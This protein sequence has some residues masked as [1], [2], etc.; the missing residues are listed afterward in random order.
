M[1]QPCSRFPWR[2]LVSTA[3]AASLALACDN[4]TPSLQLWRG[5]LRAAEERWHAA[6][7]TDYEYVVSVSGSQRRTRPVRATVRGGV[8]VGL[9]YADSGTAADTTLYAIFSTMD[10]VFANVH[11]ALVVTPYHFAAV[12]EPTFG[13]PLRWERA[14][15]GATPGTLETV[16]LT[17]FERLDPTVDAAPRPTVR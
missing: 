5:E 12:Y 16:L 10:R 14:G 15:A 17:G 13:Y 7:I 4:H 3:L 2:S 1:S 8:G 9:V 6:G 11:D